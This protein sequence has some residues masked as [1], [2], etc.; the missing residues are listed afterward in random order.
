MKVKTLIKK[1]EELFEKYGNKDV[2]L[3]VADNPSWIW[4]INKVDFERC[5]NK[6]EIT[7]D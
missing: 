7:G 2:V 1:L 6:I 4:Y 5:I 3:F